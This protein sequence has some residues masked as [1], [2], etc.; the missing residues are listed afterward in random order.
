MDLDQGG[1]L[2]TDPPGSGSE[3]LLPGT[4]NVPLPCQANKCF[5]IRLQ[6]QEVAATARVPRSP[7]GVYQGNWASRSD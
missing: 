2:N 6:V 5:H 4:G 3:T 7:G 1:D